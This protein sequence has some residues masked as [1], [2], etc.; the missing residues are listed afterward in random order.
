MSSITRS[1]DSWD[2][3]QLANLS[4]QLRNENSLGA[5]RDQ[6]VSM[7]GRL[8]EGK[9][10]VWLKESV[11]RLPDWEAGLVFP[12]RPPLEGMKLAIKSGKLFIQNKESKSSQKN[13]SRGTFAAIPLEDQG[14]T[15]GAIQITRPKG[16]AFS[17]EDLSLLQGLSQIVTVGLYASHRSEV[18]QFRLR[19]LDLVRAVSSQIANVLDLDEL[20]RRVVELI[21]KTFN[22]YYVAIFTL[23]PNSNALLFRSSASTPRRA[24]RNMLN[25]KNAAATRTMLGPP[26]QLRKRALGATPR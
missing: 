24:P 12:V 22:F 16:P 23:E 4:E 18:E 1:P 5:Q 9:A 20:V 3:R 26:G 19:Q 17:A 21:Q 11:F 10:D 13:A 15:L 2:W 25:T 14:F 7:T 6:I 8:I